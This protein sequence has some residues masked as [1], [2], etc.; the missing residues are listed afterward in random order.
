MDY[1]SVILLARAAQCDAHACANG[2]R[3][4]R[5]GRFYSEKPCFPIASAS[6]GGFDT[7]HPLVYCV[8]VRLLCV[9]LPS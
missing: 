6:K 5:A 9:W 1:F 7:G 2:S 3:L 4:T 8:C